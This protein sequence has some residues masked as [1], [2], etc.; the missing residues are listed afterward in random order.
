MLKGG[1]AMAALLLLI[2]ICFAFIDTLNPGESLIIPRVMICISVIVL[3]I[4]GGV[5]VGPI[6]WLIIS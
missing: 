3:R 2:S 5:T 4:I 6:T 1:A